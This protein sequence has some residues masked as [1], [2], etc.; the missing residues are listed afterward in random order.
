M[1]GGDLESGMGGRGGTQ[2]PA[3]PRSSSRIDAIAQ[4][5]KL[6]NEQKKNTRKIL[7]E[8]QKQ[9]TPV[10]EQIL[11]SR[12]AIGEA[13]QNGAKQEEIDHLVNASAALESQMASIELQAFS[14]IYQGLQPD[15]RN[16]TR[17]FFR[18]MRGIFNNKNWNNA[19]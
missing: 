3:A 4:M 2:M 18:M 7:D 19:E 14:K 9:A 6:D 16:L 8:A 5:L 10:H 12:L 17:D 1:S 13:I 11:K 15:Q